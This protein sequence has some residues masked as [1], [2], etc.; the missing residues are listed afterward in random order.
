MMQECWTA[1][2]RASRPRTCVDSR[3]AAPGSKPQPDPVPR[4]AH[5]GPKLAASTDESCGA[6]RL[7]RGENRHDSVAWCFCCSGMQPV[8]DLLRCVVVVAA[9]STFKEHT[10]GCH[11]D[12]R[13][14]TQDFPPLHTPTL[15]AVS[16]PRISLDRAIRQT[17]TG[18][19]WLFRGRTL[20]DRTIQVATNSPVNHVGMSVVVE[21][22]PA[23]MW[24]AELGRSLVDVWTGTHQRGAQLHDLRSAVLNWANRYGQRVWLRQLDGPV[25]REME[26]AALRTVARLDGTSFPSAPQ[27]AK[28][29]LIGRAP[30]FSVRSSGREFESAYCSEIVAVTYEAMGLLPGGRRSGWYDPGR[31]WSGDRLPL[32]LGAVLG[33]EIAVDVP[34]TDG[35]PTVPQ[36]EG[37]GPLSEEGL[38]SP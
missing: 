22:L 14:D 5:R 18:D 30:A 11:T 38:R 33:T 28:G 9:F 17:R 27:M 16:Q 26:N 23:L 25:D 1:S 15:V 21:D 31:F 3:L 32:Q 36:P 13:R 10:R 29:W 12:E 8:A 4:F 19:I 35:A 2:P 34:V 20:A 7:S 24:H 6:S 37:A